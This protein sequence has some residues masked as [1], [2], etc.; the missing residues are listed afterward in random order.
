MDRR[1]KI[2]EEYKKILDKF[3]PE[4]NPELR[5]G[6]DGMSVDVRMRFGILITV[7]IDCPPENV[8]ERILGAIYEQ[9][10]KLF[11]IAK[12]VREKINEG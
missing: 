8:Q 11:S 4:L 3:Y 1:E 9:I 10:G 6:D 5:H 12:Y 2:I 7:P